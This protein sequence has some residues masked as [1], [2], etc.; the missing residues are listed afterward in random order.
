MGNKVIVHK[1]D[2]EE[3]FED[4]LGHQ[5]G[6][7]ALQVLFMEGGSRIIFNPDDVDIVLD[8]D[9]TE[10]FKKKLAMQIDAANEEGSPA[11]VNVPVAH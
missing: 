9:T 7:G 10:E 11:E 3:V 4:V 8:D 6:N 2:V 1:N 5:I